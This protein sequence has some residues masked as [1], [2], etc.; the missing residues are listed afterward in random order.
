MVSKRFYNYFVVVQEFLNSHN[1]MLCGL[2]INPYKKY[3]TS[4]YVNFGVYRM[5][6]KYLSNFSGGRWHKYPDFPAYISSIQTHLDISI[7][8]LPRAYTLFARMDFIRAILFSNSLPFEEE[9]GFENTI[10]FRDYLWENSGFGALAD[11]VGK[12]N[13][14]YN[15]ADDIIDSILQKSM[16]N[17]IRNGK[18][19]LFK[20]E[21]V[22]D[23]FENEENKNDIK[24]YLS[25]KNVEITTRG[26]LE[27]RSDCAQPI[28]EAFAPAAF[29]LGILYS[30][31]K[32]EELLNTFFEEYKIN[33][34]NATLRDDVIYNNKLPAPKQAVAKL[35]KDLLEAAYNAL[36]NRNKNEILLL[37]PLFERA[38]NIASPALMA[39]NA[40]CE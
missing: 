3:I 26:T 7:D 16:F 33:K 24:T 20:P 22:K 39:K 23:Y 6:H 19:E 17:R 34:N 13:G 9:K 37:E 5:I 25:F 12:V 10:C 4:S 15:S 8:D 18:Y 1:H 35:L 27:M 29:N 30:L 36:S 38:S 11:N 31:N 40:L 28:K 32:A 2:G 21:L 14:I